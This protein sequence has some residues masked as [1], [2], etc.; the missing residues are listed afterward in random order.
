MRKLILVIILILSIL[1]GG[2]S[3]MAEEIKVT[4]NGEEIS[5]DEISADHSV[6]F[7]DWGQFRFNSGLLLG[8]IQLDMAGLNDIMEEAGFAPFEQNL[9]MFGGGGLF[10]VRKGARLGGMGLAGKFSTT[11]PAPK[12]ATFELNYG[13]LIYEQGIFAAGGTDI[14][15][16]ALFG[17]GTA[18]L[19]VVHGSIDDLK[20]GINNP[21]ITPFRKD[22]VLIQPRLIIY[23]Q[24]SPLVGLS[25][26]L[27]YLLSYDFGETWKIDQQVVE[28]PLENLIAPVVNLGFSIGF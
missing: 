10:G 12:K 9:L 17:G 24:I 11:G 21:I 26:E 2:F 25:L 8:M 6:V 20:D 16:G 15:V 7:S 28:G 23:Q 14:A 3:V 18:G 22:F 1:T 4:I 19:K 27:G 5:E 13:G